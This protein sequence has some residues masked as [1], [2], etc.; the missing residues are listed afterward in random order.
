MVWV[1]APHLGWRLVL[2]VVAVAHL[3]LLLGPPLPLTD[4]F[5]YELYARMAAL[6]GLNPYR[7]LPVAAHTDPV[8]ALSNWHHLSSPYGPLFTLTGEALTPLGVHGWLWGWKVV[9]GVCSLGAI[10]VVGD[11]AARLGVSRARAIAVLGLSPLLL[12]E[13]V[14]GLH[15]DVPAVLC[16]VAAVWCLVRGREDG[17]PRWTAP[18][19]GALVVAAA[20]IKPSFALVAPIV[21]LGAADRPR[22]LA[23]AA[24]AAVLAGAA[25]LLAFGTALPDVST[26]G[27]LVSPLSV[28][29]LLGLAAGHGGADATVRAVAQ[30]AVVAVAL[31]AAVVVARRRERALGAV[32]VV[33]VVT[34]LGLAWVMPWYLVWALPFLAVLPARRIAVPL[35]AAT[36]WLAGGT[37]QVP[38]I[39]HWAG[40]FP[41]HSATG[42]ANH[43]TFERLV[44]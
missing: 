30:A 9:V 24:G 32:A 18:A 17:A 4:V 15:Q 38:A 7:A 25:T 40:Y 35:V 23:G 21:V 41:T 5:N 28:P 3:V 39:I 34:V 12:I 22:A 31:G 33:L 14:G 16:L 8:F 2:G 36:L 6:H 37:A 27:T 19:A 44:R 10:V 13:E 29:N 26:Q 43:R 11:L 42:R 1:A 20:A